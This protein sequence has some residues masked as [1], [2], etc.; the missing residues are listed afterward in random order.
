MSIGWR[1]CPVRSSRSVTPSRVHSIHLYRDTYPDG[2]PKPV[3][4]LDY[5]VVNLSKQ[6][7]ENRE[8]KK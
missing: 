8:S 3:G 4:A 5:K 1:P 7:R 6:I 2:T